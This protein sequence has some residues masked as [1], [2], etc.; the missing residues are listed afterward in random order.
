MLA[1]HVLDDAFE[2]G[3]VLPLPAEPVP[4]LHHH[5]VVLAV[6]NRLADLV[7]KLLPR[8]GHGEAE[9]LGEACQQPVPVLGGCRSQRP[10]GDGAFG[11][12]QLRVRDD[13]F[14]I[15]LQLGA[16][17]AA[18]AAGAERVVEGEGPRLDLVDGEGVLVGAG[19]VF[20]ECPDPVRIFGVKVHE[21]GQDPSFGQAQCRFDRVGQPLADAVLDHEA[22]HD[23]LDGV[24]ELLAQFGRVAE[25]DEFA[26]HPRARVA[27]GGQLLE[28][29]NELAL[30]SADHGSQDLE[31]RAFCQ[32]QQLVHNLLRRLPGHGFAADGAVRPA[33]TGP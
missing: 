30:A 26:V 2:A 7:G 23:D 8:V 4:V 6:Q 21:F 13:Q 10:R 22:V 25:L 14:L 12:G 1:V 16:D 31:A 17:A 5:L 32:F 3:A 19:Q 24:L 29:V 11:E 18:R 28:Q 27:L 9:L 33:D 20:G 15:H